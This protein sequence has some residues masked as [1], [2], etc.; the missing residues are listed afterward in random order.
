MSTLCKFETALEILVGKWKPVIL[1]QLFANGTM[2][3]SELQKAIPDIT[4]K[5]LT[6]QLR[7]LQ[8]HDIIH[9]EVYNQIP[10]KVEYS[11]TEY[12][13]QLTPLLQAMNDWG[14]AHIAH[15]QEL[16]GEEH[17]ARSLKRN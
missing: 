16:Y 6:Q 5:M 15:L 7:E 11:I 3:F 14:T 8:Y 2:R 9:R 4:K 13:Q 12:G 1:L 10:P 17:S